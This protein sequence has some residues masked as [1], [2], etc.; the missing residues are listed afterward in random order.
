[1]LYPVATINVY[2]LVCT[3]GH[4]TAMQFVHYYHL[5]C[6]F[7]HAHVSNA[8]YQIHT[9]LIYSLM[10]CRLVGITMWLSL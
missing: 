2:S 3:T 5:Y 7:Q 4:K 8:H 10:Q 1:M 9:V 6:K